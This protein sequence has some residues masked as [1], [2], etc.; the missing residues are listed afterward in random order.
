V[1]ILSRIRLE[2][3][4]TKADVALGLDTS[5]IAEA[6]A[7]E[8]FSPHGLDL[9]D[10][11]VP[12]D[13]S[14]EVFVPYDHGFF[15]FVY[16]STRLAAPPSSMKELVEASPDISLLVQDPRTSSPGLG[17]MLWMRKLYGDDAG[18]AW[19]KLG[20]RIVTVTQGWSEAYGLFQ[21]GEADMVLSYTTSPAYH[22][23]AEDETKY[24]AASFTEGH[25]QQIEVAARLA[26]S[27]HGDLARDFLEFLVSE[28]AQAVIPTTQW[29]YPVRDVGAALPASFSTLV[30]VETPLGFSPSEVRQ[31]R[32]AWVAEWRDALSK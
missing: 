16:D 3:A 29:M 7:T 23:T 30:A 6:R 2:G 21:K 22:I 19:E 27:P 4:Q 24:R 8:L 26:R 11:D 18:T 25:Y 31:N 17:L 28:E 5:L 1:S 15:A 9:S 13:F 14:D 32:Q 12:G 10:L 20:P